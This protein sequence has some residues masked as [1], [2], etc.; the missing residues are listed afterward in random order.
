MNLLND[1][2][3]IFPCIHVWEFVNTEDPNDSYFK[4]EKCPVQRPYNVEDLADIEQEMNCN[5]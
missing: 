3:P 1:F 4:C 2:K 5:E